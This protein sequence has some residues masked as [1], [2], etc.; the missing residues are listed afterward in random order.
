MN[1]INFKIKSFCTNQ[2][3]IPPPFIYVTPF[4]QQS[5]GTLQTMT[6]FD[7]QIIQPGENL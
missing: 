6:A 1:L 7:S 3:R 4:L 5:Q 2:Y